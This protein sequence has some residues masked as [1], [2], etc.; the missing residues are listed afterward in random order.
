MTTCP[1]GFW[2]YLSSVNTVTHECRTCFDGCA[3]CSAGGNDSCTVCEDSSAAV[4]FYKWSKQ[5]ICDTVCPPGEYINPSIPY[6]CQVCPASCITCSSNVFCDNCTIPYFF[7]PIA[8][9]CVSKCPTNYFGN[10][11]IS[12][13]NYV[14]TQCTTGCYECTGDGLLACQSCQNDTANGLV[15]YKRINVTEC[16]TA[17]PTGS[18][19]VDTDNMCYACDT[20]CVNCSVN[21]SNCFA[22]KTV[23]SVSYYKPMTTNTCV[24]E[25]P[26]GTY[27]NQS[28]N[29][30]QTCIY[31]TYQG[32]CIL[33]CPSGTE[34]I[35]EPAPIC[36]DCNGSCNNTK[37]YSFTLTTKLVDGG[38]SLMNTVVLPVPLAK[39]ISI[40]KYSNISVYLYKE[41]RRR[42]LV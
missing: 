13:I 31:Y 23:G 27:N 21:S 12:A 22:C 19:G 14:C 42:L 41:T 11:T 29:E 7:N 34:A 1:N 17:C 39:N 26:D 30:C 37:E 4:M 32:K 6:V 40:N 33:T 28:I 20:G 24:T 9:T 18:Y 38:K 8:S 35:L 10:Q 5:T 36:R 16:T 25:C 2:P 15:Y 3:T